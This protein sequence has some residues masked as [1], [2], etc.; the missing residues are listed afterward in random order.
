M[1]KGRWPRRPTSTPG[2]RRGGAVRSPASLGV[3]DTEDAAGFRT[4][5]GSL[6]FADSA[7]ATEDSVLVAR[8][9][10]AGYVIVGKVNTPELAWKADTDN[11]VF[12]R[13]GN[14]W[15]LDRSAGGSSGGVLR[16]SL[17]DG[18]ARHGL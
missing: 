10:Q 4:T 17:R 7:P 2:S 9:R 16:P 1:P 11:R 8:M 5:K 6:L 15:A 14:P 3:K 13:T 18:P 12:G